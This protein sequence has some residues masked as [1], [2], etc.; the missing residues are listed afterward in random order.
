MASLTHQLRAVE[1][2]FLGT[3]PVRLVFSAA[4]AATPAA[5]YHALAEDTEGWAQWFGAV[6]S[7][8]PTAAGRHIVLA[9]GLHFEETVLAADSPG[10]YA[11]RADAVNRPGARAI[12]EEWRVEAAATGSRVRWTIAVD[13]TPL[14]GV[15]LRLL[16]PALGASFRGAL[17]K[18]DRRLA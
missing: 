1:L 7:A 13:P 4:V 14:T 2:D 11:Y 15:L 16:K 6:K 3:A 18:L 12:L 10:R 8:Q 5:V 17:R 9:G